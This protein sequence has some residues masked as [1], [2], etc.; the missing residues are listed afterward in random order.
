MAGTWQR[1][2]AHW[3]EKINQ[4]DSSGVNLVESAVEI[5]LECGIFVYAVE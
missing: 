1:H 2:T 5:R 4:A 3:Y